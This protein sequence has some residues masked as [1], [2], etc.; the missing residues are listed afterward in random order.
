MAQASAN[1]CGLNYLNSSISTLCPVSC[2]TCCSNFVLNKIQPCQ[3]GGQCVN[4]SMSGYACLC[5]TNCFG[6]FCSTC[7]TPTTCNLTIFNTFEAHALNRLI[8]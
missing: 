2:Q 4:V 7:V 1:K 5:P 6:T 8:E 3:N